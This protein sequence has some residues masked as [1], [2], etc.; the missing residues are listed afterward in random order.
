VNAEADLVGLP[1]K[2]FAAARCALKKEAQA[3]ILR[4]MK[5]VGIDRHSF[6]V[7]ARSRILKNHTSAPGGQQRE[8]CFDQ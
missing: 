5:P 7:P 6:V 4:L 3:V 1:Q 2:G 8:N